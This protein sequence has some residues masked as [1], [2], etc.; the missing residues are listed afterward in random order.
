MPDAHL[1]IGR[2]IP[3]R[4]R[5]GHEGLRLYAKDPERGIDVCLIFAVIDNQLTARII[6]EIDHLSNF[7]LNSMV[8]QAEQTLLNAH[9]FLHGEVF[10]VDIV[11]IASDVRN[12]SDGSLTFD[13]QDNVD[14]VINARRPRVS[15]QNIW[16]LLQSGVSL[17]VQRALN[18]LRM[19]L[20]YHHDG[21]F[22]CYKAV[23]TIRHDIGRRYGLTEK[24]EQWDRTW[25]V[26]GRSRAD[27]D[28][29]TELAR[30]LRH[31]EHVR[32]SGEKW[33]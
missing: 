14:E 8:R 25:E 32:Y 33:R 4:K 18:D 30:A 29:F 19:A 16:N 6:G 31:G 28:I 23:E 15:I 27:I 17:Y 2:V 21:P 20:K 13:Y 26:L 5:F 11:G 1:V 7:T 10:E 24:K 9:A 3:E 12:R 22:Y